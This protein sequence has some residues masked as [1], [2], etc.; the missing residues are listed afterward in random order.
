M[1]VRARSSV[2]LPWSMWPA[3]PT[4]T[5]MR[6]VA[7]RPP[8]RRRQVPVGPGSTVRR[9]KTTRRRSIRPMTAGSPAPQR[10]RASVGRSAWHRQP[11]RWQRLARAA[12]PRRRSTRVPR[13][14]RGARAK[15][16]RAALRVRRRAPEPSAESR[17][18]R[19][20]GIVRRGDDPPGRARASRPRAASDHLVRTHRPSQRIAPHAPD[21]VRPADDE[22]GLRSTDELVAAERDDVGAR[23]Q[24][25]AR[26]RLV[27]QAERARC[28]A[29]AP[30]PRSSITIAPCSWASSATAAGSGVLDESRHRE[31]RGM[32]PQ[33]DR[34][35]RHGERRLRSPRRGSG[36]WSRPRSAAL[37]P[38]RTISGIRTPPPISTS[39]PRDTTT[40]PRAR[41]SRP[42]RRRPPR[43]CSSTIASSAPVKAT[44][45]SSGARN[46]GPRRPVS[47]SSSSM[48]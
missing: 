13:P 16:R 17:C 14:R 30:E 35:R 31:V 42:R 5:V 20:T 27:R 21:Q 1:P 36:S 38:V 32:D 34:A 48:R 47:R 3:V 9:S 2:V 24:P 7:E 11:D 29:S 44:R 18:I 33:H 39:S 4:T 8:D 25:F 23:G 40:P 43:C 15:P 41:P 19:H 37:P 26:H 6:A 46:R 22:S 10:R 45:W 28:R 12:T